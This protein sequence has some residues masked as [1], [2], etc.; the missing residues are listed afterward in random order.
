[1][2]LL[3]VPL[4]PSIQESS[5]GVSCQLRLQMR[6]HT[7]PLVIHDTEIHSV[8]H[9]AVRLHHMLAEGALLERTEP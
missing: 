1:M 7:G 6:F 8:A 5:L 9:G 2:T 4:P 3:V